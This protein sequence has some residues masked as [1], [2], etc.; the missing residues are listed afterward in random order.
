MHLGFRNNID[1]LTSLFLV[2]MAVPL[3]Y[4]P[5][6]VTLS[7]TLRLIVFAGLFCAVLT[8]QNLRHELVTNI[9]QLP[10]YVRL[11]LFAIFLAITASS[12]TANSDPNLTLF[13]ATPEYMGAMSWFVFLLLGLIFMRRAKELL[14]SH[15]VLRIGL[16]ILLLSLVSNIFYISQ[17]FRLG[18]VMYQP[19]TMA[20]Y[21]LVFCS[22]SLAHLA[23][24]HHVKKLVAATF[25]TAVTTIL[26]AQSRV[27]L[28]VLELVLIAYA[29]KYIT[30][31][32]RLAIVLTTLIIA[33][34]VLPQIK[35]GYFSRFQNDSV[36][37]G[38]SYRK[39]MYK[40]S[41]PDLGRTSPVLGQGPSTLPPALNNQNYV[42]EELA[43]TLKQGYIFFSTHDLFLD[44]AYFFGCIAAILLVALNF[45]AWK[46]WYRDRQMGGA[47]VVLF[48]I[49]L[50]NALV[51]IPSLELTS[52]YFIVLF[53]MLQKLAPDKKHEKS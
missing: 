25:I 4:V 31:N 23:K 2:F 21:G 22:L 8:F 20:M 27:G 6:S 47:L 36:S 46:Y 52:L 41:I 50:A 44:F 7:K 24:D 19:T 9:R 29:L 34:A 15:A 43:V 1:A 18:G 45:L 3:L 48:F 13:G 14:F 10:G 11:I 26:L 30:S 38:V 40:T 35:P 51:N 33:V 16:A 28:V 37:K 12:I 32:R 17:G 39:D 49:L 53:A 42:P 5:D